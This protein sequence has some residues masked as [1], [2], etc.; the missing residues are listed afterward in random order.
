MSA[1]DD[2]TDTEY[3]AGRDASYA[4]LAG[5]GRGYLDP[6]DV[7]HLE[8]PDVDESALYS[9]GFSDALKG[10]AWHAQNP[11]QMCHRGAGCPDLAALET[12]NPNVGKPPAWQDLL[13]G[14]QILARHPTNKTDPFYC[15][16][17]LLTV[18]CDPAEFTAAE[19]ARLA[20]L[21]FSP[22]S[23]G[24]AFESSRFGNA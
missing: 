5:A 14:L 15:S 6:D 4:W 12:I 11:G 20:R 16:H 21:G 2:G 9:Q 17:D 8:Y 23:D 7:S 1:I 22:S 3:T 19:V 10:V 24:E 13:E 18:N